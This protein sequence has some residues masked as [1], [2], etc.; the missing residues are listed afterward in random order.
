MEGLEKELNDRWRTEG[1][2]GRHTDDSDREG[3]K[4]KP[5]K[6][7]SKKNGKRKAR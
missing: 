4:T 1:T 3:R 6:G 2:A 7:A 5:R